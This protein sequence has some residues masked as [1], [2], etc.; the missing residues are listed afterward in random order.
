MSNYEDDDTKLSDEE[1]ELIAAQEHHD[2]AV[3]KLTLD[4]L[5]VRVGEFSVTL[6]AR[7]I[8]FQAVLEYVEMIK[9]LHTEKLTVYTHM[10]NTT[11]PSVL[12]QYAE[13]LTEIEYDLQE[14]WGF[15]RNV[16][17]HK[18]WEAPKCKCP[19]MDNDDA[20]PSGYY[21][22]NTKCPVHGEAIE[23]LSTKTKREALAIESGEAE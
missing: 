1:L 13:R 5:T 2:E 17:F 20:Y 6:N 14:A 21:S 3:D 8:K 11:M 15:D 12:A 7:M 19:Q 16:R 9:D 23:A 10:Q 4:D 18:F 22:F